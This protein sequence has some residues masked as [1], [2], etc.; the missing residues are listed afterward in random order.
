MTK[1]LILAISL[2]INLL[3]SSQ[4]VYAQV[5]VLDQVCRETPN[6]TACRDNRD[7][8]T[9]Q[10][11]SIYGPDGVLTKAARVVSMIAG[12]A[13]VI[14]IIIAGLRYTLASGDPANVTKARNTITYA[15]VGLAIAAFAQGVVILLLDK[16]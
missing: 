12:I 8:Q 14:A 15:L 13:A 6:A 5:N 4:A 9:H 1:K 7:Q 3:L 10:D 16:L 2:L 11:N